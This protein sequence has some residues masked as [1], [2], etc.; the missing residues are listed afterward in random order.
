MF[1]VHRQAAK[2]EFQSGQCTQVPIL[3]KIH[4]ASPQSLEHAILVLL[5][6]EWYFDGTGCK[7][8]HFV[9]VELEWHHWKYESGWYKPR[10]FE[11]TLGLN[12]EA[13]EE[14]ACCTIP[15]LW[16]ASDKTAEQS[17][18]LLLAVRFCHRSTGSPSALSGIL[19]GAW[20][21]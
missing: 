16:G 18:G 7:W 10:V 1:F 13:S 19:R 3:K 2:A 9:F 4:S 8:D 15:S 14:V 17:N 20:Q 11:R 5:H 21:F 12:M 6:F